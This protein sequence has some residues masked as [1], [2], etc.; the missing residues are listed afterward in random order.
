MEN[1][2]CKTCGAA[3]NRIGNICVCKWCGNKWEIA[4]NDD[5]QAVERANAWNELRNGD[6]E[7]A[8]ELFEEILLKD[9]K[10]HEAYWGRALA[11]GGIVLC[12]Y[13]VPIFN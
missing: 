10:N 4:R 6:F 2:T 1:M 12:G 3:I 8:S 9:A 13:N 11:L 7:R 5:M